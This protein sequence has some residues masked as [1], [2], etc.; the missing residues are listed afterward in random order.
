MSP[1]GN[2]PQGEDG[3]GLCGG[4]G[5]ERAFFVAWF[6]QVFRQKLLEVVPI[7]P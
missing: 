1:T 4:C 2:G 5:R 3:R 6:L 7:V